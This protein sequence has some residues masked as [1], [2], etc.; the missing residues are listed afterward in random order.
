VLIRHI[1][2]EAK[3]LLG[4]FPAIGLIGPRQVG[5]TTLVKQLQQE[6]A[7]D[8]I[9]LDLELPTDIAKLQDP[10]AYLKDAE[11]KLIIIDEIQ[12]K[13]ELFNVLR[14]LIDQKNE[15]GRFIIL[16]SAAPYLI[17]KVSES[18]AGRITYLELSPF[19]YIEIKDDFDLQKHWFRGGYPKAY[20]AKKDKEAT[21]W[22][23]AYIRSYIEKDFPLLG[24]GASPRLVENFLRMIAQSQG[25]VWNASNFGRALGVTH[26]TING[27]IDFLEG[28]FFITR[29]SPFSV[30]VKKRIVKSPKIYIRDT[31]VL[32]QLARITSFE[33]LQENVLI[34]GS[35]EGYV[36]E[37]IRQLVDQNIELSYYRT[38]AGTECDLVLIKSNKPT[39]SIEIK[40]NNA[41]KITRGFL[42]SIQDL[43]T[44]NN[45]II[46]PKSDDYQLT[47][48]IRVCSIIDFLEKYLQV[49]VK[50]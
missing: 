19:N 15:N 46:T 9:Y 32:H 47:K 2:E 45:F 28:A 7:K 34:G 49:I 33:T 1:S 36:I 48:N 18:L 11:N 25:N 8:S 22:I 17:R 29:L 20:L 31:G 43:G 16:G 35:W 13:P 14:A 6:I 30:N 44:I 40:Y 41:P 39:A 10:E 23:N 27:Y 3:R 26:P 21:E 50:E 38:H 4:R 37:Q 12:H 42:E 5:K 24:L